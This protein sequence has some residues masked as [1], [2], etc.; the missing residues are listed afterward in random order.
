MNNYKTI[1][2]ETDMKYLMYFLVGIPWTITLFIIFVLTGLCLSE[3]C[4]MSGSIDFTVFSVIGIIFIS[5]SLWL[6][7]FIISLF[8]DWLPFKIKN[9]GNAQITHI[10]WVN[11][12]LIILG[13]GFAYSLY[14]MARAE[15]DTLYSIL[16]LVCFI[17]PLA[18][19]YQYPNIYIRNNFDGTNQQLKYFALTFKGLVSKSI[20]FLSIKEIKTYKTEVQERRK[21]VAFFR[22]NQTVFLLHTVEIIYETEEKEDKNLV[23]VRGRDLGGEK[24]VKQIEAFIANSI[25]KNAQITF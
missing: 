11:L 14:L 24:T 6:Q 20:P 5:G 16:G 23:L 13:G 19:M 25:A 7:F 17:F 2:K 10:G 3:G 21:S 22:S 15:G 1:Y 9:D 8:R 4:H 12:S 18:I